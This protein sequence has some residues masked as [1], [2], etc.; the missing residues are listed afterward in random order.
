M[1]TR[2]IPRAS[3]IEFLDGFS[4]RH[5]GWLV[6]VE[7]LGAVGAQTEA[8]D[9][10]LEG[11]SSEHAGRRIAITLGPSDRP[12]EH[13]VE[14]P[15]HL[16]VQEEG[17][18]DLS[19]QIESSAGETTLLSFRSSLPPE[20]VDGMLPEERSRESAP[21]KKSKAAS[22]AGGDA[23]GGKT[24][25]RIDLSL[26]EFGFVVATRAALGAGVGLLATRH[27]CRKT[28]QSVGLALLGFGALTTIPAAFLLF[29]QRNAESRSKPQAA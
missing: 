8:H 21:G 10:P 28:R 19:L 6:D 18:A 23:K 14:S 9:R 24:M 17:G 2:E 15:S 26:P 7:V 29:G 27:M 25:K 5:E 13:I 3:W 22:A 20:M 4:R 1:E 12:A 11:I 16:R